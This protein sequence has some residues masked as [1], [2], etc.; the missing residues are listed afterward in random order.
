MSTRTDTH[1]IALRAIRNLL[2]GAKPFEVEAGATRVTCSMTAVQGEPWPAGADGLVVSEDGVWP[3]VAVD[4]R[5]S[6]GA[7]R[8][9]V[10]PYRWTSGGYLGHLCI[11]VR[12]DQ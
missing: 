3:G 12:T 2:A 1:K 11:R 9:F 5:W 7:C 4:C 6:E 8:L 10:D